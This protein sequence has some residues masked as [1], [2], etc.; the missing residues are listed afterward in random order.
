MPSVVPNFGSTYKMKY[1]E[2]ESNWKEGG[3]IFFY[4]GDEGEIEL[5]YNNTGFITET[6]AK[7]FNALVIF[8]EHRY[9]GESLPF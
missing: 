2:D 5:F 7:E 1:L 4:C 9:F 6:L 8:A 3:P